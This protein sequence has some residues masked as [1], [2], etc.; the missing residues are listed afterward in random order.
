MNYYIDVQ[1]ANSKSDHLVPASLRGQRSV[2]AAV[3]I[4]VLLWIFEGAL[5][6]W[7]PGT[8]QIFYV[9]RDLIIILV[10]IFFGL[11]TRLRNRTAIW[12][13]IWIFALSILICVQLFVDKMGL[14][15][16][17]VGWRSYAAPVLLIYFVWCYA[18]KDIIVNI[19]AT[20]LIVAP[21]EL[22]ISIGQVASAPNAWV[23][24]QVGSEVAGFVNGD[25]TRVSGTF[26]AVA[27]FSAYLPVALAMS[28]WCLH[29]GSRRL[30]T[31]GRVA[32]V[33]L[34]L[35]VLISGSRTNIFTAGAVLVGYL[36]FHIT[37]MSLKS[38]KSVVLICMLLLISVT[39]VNL[40]FPVVVNNF[41][42]RFQDAGMSENPFD[43]LEYQSVGYLSEPLTL[44]GNGAGLNS[45]AG[46]SVGSGGTWIEVDSIRWVAELG[47]VGWLLAGARLIV[48][49]WIVISFIYRPKSFSLLSCLVYA[50]LL[51][52]LASGSVTQFPT[53]QGFFAISVSIL[54]LER[55][56]LNETREGGVCV[57]AKCNS[58]EVI[59]YGPEIG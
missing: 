6:K 43:R 50:S 52:V 8:E 46:I 11:S 55:L 47:L 14:T 58:P 25:T 39:V 45:M 2:K 56:G 42:T 7:V 15:V 59:E 4:Y 57:E 16:G 17:V 13:W 51:P 28:L 9:A 24:K 20:V 23:N 12:F 41:L 1:R 30:T 3:V 35:S 36:A 33:C 53:A 32:V 34:F 10:I 44:F 29:L 40:V 54:V 5:R 21:I 27:G 31:I 48:C 26:S 49:F 37:R 18:V 19:A 22:L 38:L